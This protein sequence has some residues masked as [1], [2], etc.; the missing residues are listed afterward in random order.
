MT[1]SK[2]TY[3]VDCKKSMQMWKSFIYD[4]RF[5]MYLRFY[6]CAKWTKKYIKLESAISCELKAL[7]MI[8][9]W[10][11]FWLKLWIF[12]AHPAVVLDNGCVLPKFMYYLIATFTGLRELHGIPKQN[13]NAK[14]NTNIAYHKENL[15]RTI[16]L[17]GEDRKKVLGNA[18]CPGSKGG[19]FLTEREQVALM[20]CGRTP[21]K[22][23]LLTSRRRVMVSTVTFASI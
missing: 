9:I 19:K 23:G 21:S 1:M 6:R 12:F 10:L 8:N 14:V 11:T 17:F 22:H 5:K 16:S 4:A 7:N 15:F 18:F 20:P 3:Q 13:L 2:K